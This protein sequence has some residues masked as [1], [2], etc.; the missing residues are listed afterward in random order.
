MKRG[1]NKIKDQKSK[2]EKKIQMMLEW[3][4]IPFF[5]EV[6][7]IFSFFFLIPLEEHQNSL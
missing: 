4:K 6:T 7:K 5:A 1:K 3:K 2:S